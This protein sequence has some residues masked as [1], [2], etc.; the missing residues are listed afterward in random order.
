MWTWSWASCRCWPTFKSCSWSLIFFSRPVKSI[1]VF[2]ESPAVPLAATM[3]FHKEFKESSLLRMVNP[4]IDTDE[5]W[6]DNSNVTKDIEYNATNTSS[7]KLNPANEDTNEDPNSDDFSCCINTGTY[8]CMLRTY[9]VDDEQFKSW[10]LHMNVF[11]WT[12]IGRSH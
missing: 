8:D 9:M 3:S 6:N 11:T 5:N 2:P 4:F 10:Y 7:P 1:S 12:L